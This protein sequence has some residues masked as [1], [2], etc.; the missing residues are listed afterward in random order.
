MTGN[1]NHSREY[2]RGG[3][4]RGI[5]FDEFAALDAQA[6][7]QAR[8]SWTHLVPAIPARL[9]GVPHV[10]HQRHSRRRFA[11]EWIEQFD[12]PKPA[13]ASSTARRVSLLSMWNNSAATNLPGD[14]LQRLIQVPTSRSGA[15]KTV[16]T[17][18]NYSNVIEAIV[19]TTGGV[20]RRSSASNVA[21]NGWQH[22]TLC[23]SNGLAA[24]PSTST[25]SWTSPSANSCRSK[26]APADPAFVVGQS[27]FTSSAS[28]N[29]MVVTCV[30][31]PTAI[32]PG[33]NCRAGPRCRRRITSAIVD[34]GSTWW[35]RLS[36]CRGRG[37]HGQ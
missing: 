6:R 24:P 9:R 28:F 29:G 13:R 30:H 8:M 4:R 10:S 11:P 15:P 27:P 3:R 21:T 16:A 20:V 37:G 23:W 35:C 26:A 33:R 1:C 7:A 17:C 18:G 2:H 5:A 25:A 22:I 12:S 31:V 34:A 36:V 32:G 14:I 19:P